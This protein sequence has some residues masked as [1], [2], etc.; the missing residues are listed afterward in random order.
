[1][2]P[3]G[4]GA[5]LIVTVPL[6]VHGMGGIAEATPTMNT[7]RSKKMIVFRVI[8]LLVGSLAPGSGT[9]RGQGSGCVHEQPV[10]LEWVHGVRV[11]V[12]A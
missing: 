5:P 2:V 4:A 3:T 7:T 6:Y 10:A 12:A 9:D 8:A 1:V 11:A